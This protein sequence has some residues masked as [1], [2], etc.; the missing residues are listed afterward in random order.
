MLKGTPLEVKPGDPKPPA[1]PAVALAPADKAREHEKQMKTYLRRQDVCD[2]LRE[3][4]RDTNDASLA[5]E[6]DRLEQQAFLVYQSATGRLVASKL[7]DSSNGKSDGQ[8]AASVLSG[9]GR[10]TGSARRTA[11]LEEGNR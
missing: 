4:A 10:N 5:Q 7:D 2:R 1:A 8:G 9:Q 11:S 6:A 3:I